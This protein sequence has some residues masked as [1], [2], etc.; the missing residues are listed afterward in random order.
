M[1][2]GGG[3]YC[4]ETQAQ[5][6]AT[7][8]T[9][10]SCG[11]EDRSSEVLTLWK[12]RDGSRAAGQQGSRGSSARATG[13][14]GFVDCSCAI[15]CHVTKAANSGSNLSRTKRKIT[16]QRSELW[17]FTYSPDRAVRGQKVAPGCERRCDRDRIV[18]LPVTAPVIRPKKKNHNIAR[19]QISDFR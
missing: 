9:A 18:E 6:R 1:C 14:P 19:I 12:I 16:D 11:T 10:L 17:R 3:G 5:A 7:T 13:Q 8:R 15:K 2:V 4:A